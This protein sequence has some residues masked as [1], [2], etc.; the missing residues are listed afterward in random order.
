MVDRSDRNRTPPSRSSDIHG[1][2]FGYRAVH[3]HAVLT[4]FSEKSVADASAAVIFL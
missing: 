3:L 2:V 4:T 1:G